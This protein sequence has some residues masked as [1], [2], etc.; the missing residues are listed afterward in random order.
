M[1]ICDFSSEKVDKRRIRIPK[2]IDATILCLTAYLFLI[3]GCDTKKTLKKTI[4]PIEYN[5]T[6]WLEIKGFKTKGYDVYMSVGYGGEGEECKFF[7]F[8]LG[9]DVS[10]SSH[11]SFDA[12][13]S[14]DDLHYTLR[15]PLNF[16]QG[17]CEFWAGGMEIRM[18]EYNT[19]D[20]KKYPKGDLRRTKI[21]DDNVLVLNFTYQ[22]K[23][24]K[25]NFNL[26]PLNLYCQRDVYYMDIYAD[27]TD[28]KVPTFGATCHNTT[29]YVNVD[30]MGVN[31]S[32]AFLK[33]HNPLT[34]NLLISEDLKCSRHCNQEEMQRAKVLG[35][36]EK[37]VE[38]RGKHPPT[39]HI[40]NHW[41][42]PSQKLFEDFK[43]KHNIKE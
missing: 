39:T 42:I 10:K 11:L 31:Y 24:Y 5:Q 38:I 8:G 43:K 6:T 19:L 12:N 41:F 17:K 3:S 7:S 30:S 28:E 37:M 13:I 40:I 2:V 23:T 1:G 4:S 18:E 27:D 35:V 20:K 32:V 25:E 15:Y 36:K 33:K 34:I 16:K 26:N 29:S 14:K 22:K 9:H 21:F